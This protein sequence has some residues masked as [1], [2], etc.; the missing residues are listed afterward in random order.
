MR[1]VLSTVLVHVRLQ[2]S[3]SV[4]SQGHLE[5][6]QRKP[7]PQLPDAEV[8]ILETCILMYILS[9]FF[10]TVFLSHNASM[11]NGNSKIMLDCDF[12]WGTSE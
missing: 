12:V 5:R 8:C 4:L 1:A 7:P 3:I 6:V 10:S 11:E 2:K 9:P